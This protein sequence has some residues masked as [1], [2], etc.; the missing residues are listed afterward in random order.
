MFKVSRCALALLGPFTLVVGFALMNTTIP[1]SAGAGVFASPQKKG[2]EKG[3]ESNNEKKSKGEPAANEKKSKG[4]SVAP[5]K[6]GIPALWEDRGDISRLNL[7]M[8]IGSEKGKPK[9]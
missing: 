9:P 2:K 4:E 1:A 3:K 7:V 5:T 8:G 6:A